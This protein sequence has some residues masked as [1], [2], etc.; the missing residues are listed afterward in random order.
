MAAVNFRYARALEE[1]VA[2][3]R[4]NAE[5]IKQQQAQGRTKGNKQRATTLVLNSL[6][7]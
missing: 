4:L 1:V 3:Q 7:K 6:V 2:G 5:A